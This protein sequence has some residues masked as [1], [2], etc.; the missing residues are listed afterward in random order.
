ME[1]MGGDVSVSQ[2]WPFLGQNEGEDREGKLEEAG[3][4]WDRIHEGWDLV[5][6][7]WDVGPTWTPASEV[8]G[9]CL[10]C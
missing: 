1:K 8:R 9:G 6:L 2:S 10:G 3:L 5:S 4:A 7:F